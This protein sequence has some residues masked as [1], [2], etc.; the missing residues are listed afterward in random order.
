MVMTTAKLYLF[1]VYVCATL[2]GCTLFCC[3][4]SPG[5]YL[6]TY[7]GW[8]GQVAYNTLHQLD[9]TTMTWEELVPNNPSDAP[10]K[11]SGCGIVAYGD[12]KLVLFGGYGVPPEKAL[13]G[14]V[15]YQRNTGSEEKGWTN[16]LKVFN[17]EEGITVRICVHVIVC[18]CMCEHVHECVTVCIDVYVCY[19][20]ILYVAVPNRN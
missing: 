18:I 6:Y 19:Q 1:T 10:M 14:S 15:F 9:T 8:D 4:L 16:E 13:P 12:H 17:I 7:G 5:H 2:L 11:M 20:Y 3:V